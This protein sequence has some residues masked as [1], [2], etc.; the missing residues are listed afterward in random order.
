[1]KTQSTTTDCRCKA[2]GALLAKLD[3]DSLTIRRGDMQIVV[4]G[5]S[6]VS[7]TCYRDRCRT[8]NV[9]ASRRPTTPSPASALP[10]ATAA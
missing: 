7:V 3:R 2:C 6:T 4:T 1:M 10:R 8:L 9:L 5:D